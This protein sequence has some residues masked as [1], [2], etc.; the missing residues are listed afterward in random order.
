M[1]KV[2]C[3][4]SSMGGPERFIK[5]SLTPQSH[6]LVSSGISANFYKIL[7]GGTRKNWEHVCWQWSENNQWEDSFMP[8]MHFPEESSAIPDASNSPST[9]LPSHYESG[10]AKN[11]GKIRFRRRTAFF[12]FYLIS[13]KKKFPNSYKGLSWS[14]KR[15]K[16]QLFFSG[17]IKM[18]G[19]SPRNMEY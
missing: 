11:E 9:S 7:P 17:G 2:E 12:A 13:V 10:N 6:S 8:P 1:F 16:S 19:G 18:G 15:K 4:F 3:R 5:Q 14:Q